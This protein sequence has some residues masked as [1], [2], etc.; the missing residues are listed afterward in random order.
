[1]PH[2]PHVPNESFDERG[3]YD[4]GI[5]NEIVSAKHFRIQHLS[6]FPADFAF[7]PPPGA[8]PPSAA[9]LGLPPGDGMSFVL[10]Y[11]RHANSLRRH[12]GQWYHLN[13]ERGVT[14]LCDAASWARIPAFKRVFAVGTFAKVAARGAHGDKPGPHA[15]LTLPGPS[16]RPIRISSLLVPAASPRVRP[17]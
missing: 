12:D 11:Q 8:R 4:G 16:C 2:M 10:T 14:H 15:E 17:G 6:Q 1:M 13:S 3:N 7:V 9:Q 5:F